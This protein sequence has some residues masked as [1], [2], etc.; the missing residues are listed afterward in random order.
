MDPELYANE[1]LKTKW[2]NIP[3]IKAMDK[4]KKTIYVTAINKHEYIHNSRDVL[5]NSMK[6][7]LDRA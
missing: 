3:F 4:Q 1:L 6:A 2:P 5:A 7:K